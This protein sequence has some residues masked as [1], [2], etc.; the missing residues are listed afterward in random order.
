MGIIS[1]HIGSQ[2]KKGGGALITAMNQLVISGAA[3]SFNSNSTA[4]GWVGP[5][6]SLSTSSTPYFSI[7]LTGKRFNSGLRIS[8]TEIPIR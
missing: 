4:W 3:S 2:K 6:A 8:T 7:N 5:S 1:G